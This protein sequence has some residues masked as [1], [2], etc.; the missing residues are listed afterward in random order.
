MATATPLHTEGLDQAIEALL[1]G[2]PMSR[3]R[4]LVGV[5]YERLLLHRRDRTS[6]PLDV[7]QQL[8]HGICV[9]LRATPEQEAGVITRALGN[10]FSLSMEPGGQLEVATAPRG[11][12]GE[13]DTIMARVDA[14][15]LARLADSPYELVPLGH[16]PVTPVADL[17]LLPKSRY[18]LMD[19][20]M[21]KRGSLT[22]NMMRGTAGF[23]VA[24]DVH[25]R[26]D[27]A[28][29]MALL[30]RLSPALT[31]LA[32]NSRRV[33]GQ[34]SGYASYRREVWRNTDTDRTGV[35][36]GCLHPETSIE[37]YVDF[38]KRATA[39]FQ[40]TP[41]G[42]V[43]APELPFQAWVAQGGVTLEDL[44]QHLSSLFP[45]VRIR[46]YIE[47]RCCDSVAWPLVRG[48]AALLTGIMYCPEATAAAEAIAG[49]L[50]RGSDEELA[51]LHDAAARHGLAAPIG[52]GRTFAHLLSDLIEPAKER[53]G[54]PDCGW[55]GPTD[56]APVAMAVARGMDGLG[57]A[58]APADAVG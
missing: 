5:E 52:G 38:V 55:G 14:A 36:L 56:L 54:K 2:S 34:D 27:A 42:V 49:E 58:G 30:F 22:R 43:A 46:N 35:P 18:V 53:L 16:A 26:E 57:D 31:A 32:A 48:T 10:D 6:A 19:A 21:P 29:K 33:A 1:L 51:A 25:S 12:L 28:R 15:I 7:C 8:M 17:P 45:E 9:D 3:R 44:D 23:Q 20:A 47:I 40:V 41:D 24:L 39:L 50:V 4:R 13:L 37:A 11:K